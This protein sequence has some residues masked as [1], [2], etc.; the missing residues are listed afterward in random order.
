MAHKITLVQAREGLLRTKTAAGLSP[1]TIADYKNTFKKLFLSFSCF[2]PTK[3]F[4][5]AQRLTDKRPGATP[6][7]FKCPGA[8]GPLHPDFMRTIMHPRYG[9]K[10]LSIAL[11]R[12]HN[13]SWDKE[14]H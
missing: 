4:K 3:S 6:S 9:L 5:S 10:V 7:I 13:M 14:H 11:A 8:I 2:I 1:H 12:S